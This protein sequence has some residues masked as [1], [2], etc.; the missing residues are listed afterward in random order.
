MNLDDDDTDDLEYDHMYPSMTVDTQIYPG[1]VSGGTV[2]DSDSDFELGPFI[3][4]HESPSESDVDEDAPLITTISGGTY[5]SSDQ[6]KVPFT[7]AM[8]DFVSFI[9]NVKL[10]V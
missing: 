7:D 2:S 10:T 1:T 8:R 3:D 5:P 9:G 4:P 6:K